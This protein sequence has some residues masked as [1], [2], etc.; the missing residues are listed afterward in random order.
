MSRT[1]AAAAEA[2]EGC[3]RRSFRRRRASLSARTRASGRLA[4]A[5]SGQ[6]PRH[7]RCATSPSSSPRSW[8]PIRSQNI[9]FDWIE[10]A[11]QVRIRVD[12]DEARLLGLSS[13]A[14]ASVLNTVIS[15]TPSP[16]CATTSIWSMSL[17]GDGR[18]A[19]SLIICGPCRCRCRA[20]NGSAQSVRDLRIRAGISPGLAGRPRSDP[21]SASRYRR[22]EPFRRR[23]LVHFRPI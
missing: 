21:D 4:G 23:W 19:G 12:Q 20:A 15:G 2:R 3:S 6:R 9:N 7:D 14:V 11:R 13:Q 22:R 16:R 5:I 17:H 1:R 10:P 8:R 18:T